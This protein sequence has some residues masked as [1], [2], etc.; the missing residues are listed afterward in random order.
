[1]SFIAQSLRQAKQWLN[2]SLTAPP[3]GK[4]YQQWRERFIRD[5]LKLTL[6]TSLIFLTI[7]AALNLGLILP[8][9]ERNRNANTLI[10]GYSLAF[11]VSLV[12]T[13]MLGL[14]LNLG[15][16]IRH[17]QPSPA[18]LRAA[19]FGYSSAVMLVPQVLHMT[20][21]NTMLDLGGWLIFFLLQ[22]VLIPVRW[23]WHLISQ[24]LLIVLTSASFLVLHLN[25]PRV[26]PG[27][28]M[29][30]FVQ[31][32]VVIGCTFGLANFGV[33]LYERLL[34]REFELRQQLQLFLHAVSHDLR[35]PVTGALML[36]KNL[37]A[38]AGNVWMEQATVNQMIGGHERQL[39]LINSLLEAHNQDMGGVVLH[40]EA[41]ALPKLIDAV[42]LDWQPMLQ[43]TQSNAQVALSTNLPLVMVDPL[44][45]RR[46]YDNLIDNALQ[47]NRPG[48]C[49]TLAATQQDHYVHCTVRD[50][51]QGIG[52][53]TS[54]NTD[55]ASLKPGLFD[56]YSRG[57]NSRQ[58]LHLGLG[59]YICQQIIEAH[60]GQIGVDS[61][62]NQGTTFWFTLPLAD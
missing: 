10:E 8:A 20:Q 7:L 14:L 23:S 33:Y 5:R 60:G 38:H 49:I 35:N 59:L 19:F 17:P 11:V 32:I 21:G 30:V 18:H 47:Y 36:L 52:N 4:E 56:R 48:L 55:S 25:F 12:A 53:P 58:P 6:V 34:R 39:K 61:K 43:Q 15:L 41:I 28:Q 46:V 40:R 13:Q 24:G 22:A 42:V 9:I 62:L 27:M 45:V 54:D 3:P 44:Q 50:N 51:G 16:L 2:R 37:P 31:F 57:I 26:A 29:P 1:M